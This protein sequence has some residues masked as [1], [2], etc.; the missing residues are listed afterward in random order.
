MDRELERMAETRF[1]TVSE[2]IREAIRRTFF[3]PEIATELLNHVPN[4]DNEQE[5]G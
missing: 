4:G 1:T 5:G 2:L 3:T